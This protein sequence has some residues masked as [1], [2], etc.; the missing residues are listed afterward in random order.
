MDLG[1][2]L[3]KYKKWWYCFD[4]PEKLYNPDELEWMGIGNLFE[5][6]IIIRIIVMSQ[7]WQ[8]TEDLLHN[9]EQWKYEV[10]IESA[11]FIM[12]CLYKKTPVMHY[13]L[14][15]IKDIKPK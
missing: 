13:L 5:P 6:F 12:E 10:C 1:E 11:T 3:A 9:R 15:H 2:L 14:I 7:M 4:Y 8:H